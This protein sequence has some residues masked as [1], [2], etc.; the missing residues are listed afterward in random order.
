MDTWP[1]WTL[2]NAPP[3]LDGARG[4]SH[5]RTDYPK[6][7]VQAPVENTPQIA[8]E[9]PVEE[10][11]RLPAPNAPVDRIASAPGVEPVE[12]APQIAG[13]PPVEDQARLPVTETPESGET[14]L[15]ALPRPVE[16]GSSDTASIPAIERAPVES[17]NTAAVDAAPMDNAPKVVPPAEHPPMIEAPPQIHEPAQK[18]GHEVKL[19]RQGGAIILEFSDPESNLPAPVEKSP[20]VVG[21][22]AKHLAIM[23]GTIPP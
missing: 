4:G 13:Q 19:E 1:A 15:A 21:G 2:E 14:T 20:S 12:N 10:R 23:G 22:I 17:D 7:V 18:Q 16:S 9:P 5:Y 3:P 11:A 6:P 8:E